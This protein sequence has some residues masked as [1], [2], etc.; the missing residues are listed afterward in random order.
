MKTI[1][2]NATA[3]PGT[4][5]YAAEK[6]GISVPSLY[7]LIRAGKLATFHVGRAHRVTDAAIQTCIA[8]LESEE[9]DSRQRSLA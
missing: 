3:K 4:L 5:A 2:T 7:D 6:I 1:Q 8:R 9:A